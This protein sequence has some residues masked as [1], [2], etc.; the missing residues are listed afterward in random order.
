MPGILNGLLGMPPL[1]GV[2]STPKR[3]PY[4]APPSV[5][6]QSYLTPLDPLREA[7]FQSWV[8]RNNVPFDPSLTADYDMRG[9]WRALQQRDPLAVQ[10]LNANDGE[11]HFPD[12]WKTPYHESFSNESQF[13]LPGAPRWNNLDQLVS[14]RGAVVF[15]ERQKAMLRALLSG[16][17]ER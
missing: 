4:G 9:F 14:P 1:T 16:D 6:T 11:M 13:A 15:D 5:M 10:S 17:R 12:Y 7:A 3:S 8:G 2:L